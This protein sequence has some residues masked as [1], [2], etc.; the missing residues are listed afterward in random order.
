MHF[1]RKLPI[2]LVATPPSASIIGS[3]SSQFFTITPVNI[4][5][6]ESYITTVSSS[7]PDFVLS[8]TTLIFFGDPPES[9]FSVTFAGT[10]ATSGTITIP[11][12]IV[13]LVIPVTGS[14]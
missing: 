4:G 13:D 10:S 8:T 7:N 9:G 5:I 12:E 2:Y 11:A 3:G 14:P 1:Y 6:G